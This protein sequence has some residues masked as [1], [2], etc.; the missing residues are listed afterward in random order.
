[1]IPGKHNKGV[2]NRSEL[3]PL[4]CVLGYFAIGKVPKGIGGRI[5]I[6]A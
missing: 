2:H 4:Y 5:P 6:L 1:M 3:I